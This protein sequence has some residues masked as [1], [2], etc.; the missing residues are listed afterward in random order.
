MRSINTR[1]SPRLSAMASD[2]RPRKSRRL[3]RDATDPSM[4]LSSDQQAAEP[5][6][7]CGNCRKLNLEAMICDETEA[8]SIGYPSDFTDQN[9]P[10]C[11][12][13]SEATRLA[14]DTE[15]S[16]DSANVCFDGELF[17]QSR[18]P[19]VSIREDCDVEKYPQ[20]RLLLA[21]DQ[22]PPN[23]P[24]NRAIIR[25]IDRVKN[26]FIIA[27]IESL[28]NDSMPQ[29]TNQAPCFSRRDIGAKIDFQRVK[30][31]LQACKSHQHS[32]KTGNQESDGLFQD[33]GFRLIDVVDE[34]LVQVTETCE[35]VALSY[36]WGQ[37]P[38]RLYTRKDNVETLSDPKGITT[39]TTTTTT[40]TT[41]PAPIIA[42]TVLDAMNFTREIGIRYLW[43]DALCIVQDNPVDRKEMIPR[44]SEVYGNATLTIIDAAG[45]DANAGL[46]GISPRNGCPIKPTIVDI[47]D[48]TLKLAISLPSLSELV[49]KSTWNGRGWTY[50]EQCLSQ[51]CLYFTDEE[52]FFNC[53][54]KQ[55]REGYFLDDMDSRAQIRTGPPWWTR[56]LREDRDPAPFSHLGGGTSALNTQDYQSAVRDYSRRQLSYQS[57]GLKA[58]AGAFSRFVRSEDTPGLTID[59]TQGIPVHL[60]FQAILWFPL[61]GARRCSCSNPKFSTWSW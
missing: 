10:L 43:V 20:P 6:Q 18:S 7:L 51:R 44:M 42:Q 50:Q 55:W 14:W 34:R 28:P 60:L 16:G 30:R 4:C 1:Q 8:K 56:N 48:G 46:M 11:N 58:F 5:S 35:Y 17:M 24:P 12:L 3:N 37:V 23:F 47:A 26:R 40:T 13:I 59:Q 41:H 61:G 9:C 39:A 52:V 49:R 22:K 2:S 21:V 27:E 31:W 15:P 32:K 29:R 57:D 38:S 33:P 19:W 25:E 54:E 45:K 53:S 36:V